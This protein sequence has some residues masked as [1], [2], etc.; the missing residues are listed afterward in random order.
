MKIV[1][2]PVNPVN[3]QL[4]T[5]LES[6]LERAKTGELQAL[7]FAGYTINDDITTGMAMGPVSPFLVHAAASFLIRRV[8]QTIPIPG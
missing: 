5:Y 4:V 1:P 2:P 7:A 6:L 3:E 8:E